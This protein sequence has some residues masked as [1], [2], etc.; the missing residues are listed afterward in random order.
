[1]AEANTIM[2]RGA[3]SQAHP[4]RLYAA[5]LVLGRTLS[6]TV[7]F[8]LADMFLFYRCA[9][10]PV[11]P[12]IPDRLSRVITVTD[13]GGQRMLNMPDCVVLGQT[14]LIVTMSDHVI[15]FA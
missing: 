12:S 15:V 11:S 4:S 9:H 7:H 14:R 8:E 5:G 2:F 10:S 3:N 6:C 13:G 1:M